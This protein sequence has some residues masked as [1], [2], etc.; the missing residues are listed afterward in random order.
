[1]V[2]VTPRPRFTPGERTPGT[3]WTGG[4]VGPRAGLFAETRRNILCP[5][6][7]SNPDRPARSQTL[8]CLSNLRPQRILFLGKCRSVSHIFKYNAVSVLFSSLMEPY[9]PSVLILCL[10]EDEEN[11]ENLRPGYPLLEP[12]FEPATSLILSNI[13][14]HYIATFRSYEF[15]CTQ[16]FIC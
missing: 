4:W 10:G 11:N 5:C 13:A 15:Y 16:V 9:Q 3:H 7:G 6:R 14:S 8:Y 2:S 1:V 12:K